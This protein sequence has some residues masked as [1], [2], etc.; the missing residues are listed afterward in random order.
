MRCMVCGGVNVQIVEWI[1]PNAN[2]GEGEIV[3]GEPF[4]DHK[5]LENH[6]PSHGMTW[7][8]DCQDNTPLGECKLCEEPGAGPPRHKA[9]ES[10]ESGKHPHC[11]CDVCQ[12][13]R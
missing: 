9:S 6:G 11:T 8:E 3:N 12:E 13:V 5:G 1:Y 2:D 4:L 7:C 10:C